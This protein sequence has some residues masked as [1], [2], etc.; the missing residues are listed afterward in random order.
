MDMEFFK[1]KIVEI[2]MNY[3]G[4]GNCK[5]RVVSQNGTSGFGI[6]LSS[7]MPYLLESLEITKEEYEAKKEQAL[8]GKEFETHQSNP[9]A[10]LFG[11]LL[12]YINQSIAIP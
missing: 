6:L 11:W 8:V 4:Q 12:N 5:V 2:I 10:A 9:T 1:T 3:D 7:G